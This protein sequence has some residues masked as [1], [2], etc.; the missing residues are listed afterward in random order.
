MLRVAPVKPPNFIAMKRP[1]R[2]L[3]L[4]A[5]AAGPAALA[6]TPFRVTH[7]T[8]SD[9]SHAATVR[10]S[11]DYPAQ[12][13]EPLLTNARKVILARLGLPDGKPLA[14]PKAALRPVVDLYME[15]FRLN[16]DDAASIGKGQRPAFT[17]SFDGTVSL[18]YE[19]PEVV[20]FRYEAYSYSGGAH[21]MPSDLYFTLE[22]A[23]G[24]ELTWDDIFKPGEARAE[25]A[26]LVRQA[27]AEQFY[28]PL[29]ATPAYDEAPDI[30]SFALPQLDP[31]FVKVFFCK[32]KTAYEIDSY[33]AGMPECTLSYDALAPYLTKAAKALVP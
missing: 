3:L 16:Y 14:D 2:L 13:S 18:F 31:A 21:G 1:G 10:V 19:S 6:Q 32:Q 25:L 27:V 28:A 8:L 33:A 5:L 12:G 17:Y 7:V 11:A 26:A 22:R 15:D 20:T 23:T 29:G 9:S 30:F 4:A 24:R